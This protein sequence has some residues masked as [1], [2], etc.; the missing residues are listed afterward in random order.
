MRNAELRKRLAAELAARKLQLQRE[1][2]DKMQESRALAAGS[3]HGEGADGV[4][5]AQSAVLAE[6]DRAEAERDRTELALI[7]AAERRL[8]DGTYGY[9]VTC[10]VA[11]PATRLQAQP[12]ASRCTSCQTLAERTQH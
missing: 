11:I 7:D 9:C 1:V 4:D 3:A 2:Q 8:A 12:T 5:V 10:G 6:R